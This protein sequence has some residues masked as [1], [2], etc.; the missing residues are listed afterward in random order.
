MRAR[1]AVLL[2]HSLGGLAIDVVCNRFGRDNLVP[3]QQR[4]LLSLSLVL[5][6]MLSVTK[7]NHFFI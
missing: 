1:S 4:V 2:L 5:C 3:F 7:K 6:P